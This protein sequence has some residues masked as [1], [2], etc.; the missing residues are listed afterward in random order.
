M[1]KQFRMIILDHLVNTNPNGAVILF[2][3]FCRLNNFK[4]G[5][6]ALDKMIDKATGFEKDVVNK[7]SFFVAKYIYLPLLRQLKTTK[8]AK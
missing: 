8:K 1:S 5:T 7:F 4:L 6:S 2:K 3:E